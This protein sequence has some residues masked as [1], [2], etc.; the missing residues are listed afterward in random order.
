M[1]E[2]CT[3]PKFKIGQLVSFQE[4]LGS[5]WNT[6]A[7]TKSEAFAFECEVNGLPEISFLRSLGVII[8]VIDQEVYWVDAPANSIAH[9]YVWQSQKDLKNYVL[10]E[11]EIKEP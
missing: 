9:V 5:F 2:N 11:H 8:K 6:Y 4:N 10:F 3:R 7:L 1:K